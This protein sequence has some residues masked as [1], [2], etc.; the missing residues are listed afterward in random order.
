[1]G[2]HDPKNFETLKYHGMQMEHIYFKADL[3]LGLANEKLLVFDGI[4]I[5][6]HYRT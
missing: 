6:F 5:T 4:A 2:R 3:C 1:M